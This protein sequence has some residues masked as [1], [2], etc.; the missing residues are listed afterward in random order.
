M[1]ELGYVEQDYGLTEIGARNRVS[2]VSIPSQTIGLCK[3]GRA[4]RHRNGGLPPTWLLLN[5]TSAQLMRT[6]SIGSRTSDSAYWA[7]GR[8]F[9]IETHEEWSY[10][11]A[12]LI[13][14]HKPQDHISNRIIANLRI[15]HCVIN[16]VSWPL[17]VKIFPNAIRAYAIHRAYE[18]LRF[19]RTLAAGQE[20]PYLV[21]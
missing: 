2:T 9:R 8:R 19:R 17:S 15:H 21:F 14:L 4:L 16:R 7:L 11:N 12:R 20:S 13:K 18:I 10:C 5:P 3:P 6:Q 1:H